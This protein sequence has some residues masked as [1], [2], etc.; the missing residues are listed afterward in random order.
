M[1]KKTIRNIIITIVGLCL[2]WSAMAITDYIRCKSFKEPIFTIGTNRDQNGNGYYKCIGYEIR[3]VAREFNGNKFVKYDMQFSLFGRGRGI[4]K[5]I[6][7]NYRHNLGLLGSDK[8]TVLNYLEALKCVTP[9]VSGNQETYTEYVKENGIEVMN[10][11]LYNDVVAG[12][13]YEYYD[14]QAAYDFATHLRKDLELTFG[15]KST[16]P[17]MVQ[18][19]KD[20]FDN[21]KNVS[22]L[23]SQYTYYEDWKAAFDY[24][25]KENIDKMLDGKDYSRIDIHFEL[26]VID[27]NNAT[28]S[29]RYVALPYVN[30]QSKSK[31]T[32]HQFT[33]NNLDVEVTN[34]HETKKQ[35]ASDGFDS[36]EYAE[37]IVYPGAEVS[38]KNADMRLSENGDKYSNW[39]FYKKNDERIYIV[40]DKESIEITEDL[41]G[42]YDT[43]SSVYVLQFEMYKSNVERRRNKI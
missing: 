38:I 18:T 41:V 7:D 8:E 1:K 22:E 39:A 40:D 20:Y 28:V 11:I 27:A 4:K 26:S 37:Y 16:Y 10:M 14:L 36:W 13:E 12:F 3:S 2:I 42:I 25:K 9:D 6:Y 17:G 24:Q 34:V 33:Y 43:E 35:T 23:K 29:V 21:V 31:D 30:Q 19:N 15:E 32:T 5:T